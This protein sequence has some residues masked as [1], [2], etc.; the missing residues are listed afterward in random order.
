[1]TSDPH[2]FW[3]SDFFYSVFMRSSVDDIGANNLVS[4]CEMCIL[5]ILLNYLLTSKKLKNKIT[6]ELYNLPSFL[7]KNCIVVFSTPLLLSGK[8]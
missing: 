8:L 6:S 7:V 3:S 5:L 2:T 1:M 4:N